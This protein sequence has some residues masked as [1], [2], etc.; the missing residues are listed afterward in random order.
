[1]RSMLE[2]PEAEEG[3]DE[4]TEINFFDEANSEMRVKMR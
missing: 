4:I 3:F 1:M 2:L